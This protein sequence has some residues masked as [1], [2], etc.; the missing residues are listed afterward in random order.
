MKTAAAKKWTRSTVASP[1]RSWSGVKL[2]PSPGRPVG[3]SATS[4]AAKPAT[5]LS[6]LSH[7][8]SVSL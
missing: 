8:N 1:R 5:V 6:L 3:N 7:E 4:T 2:T